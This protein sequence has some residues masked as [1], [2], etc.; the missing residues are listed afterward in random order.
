MRHSPAATTFLVHH[1][2]T[3]AAAFGDPWPLLGQTRSEALLLR[4]TLVRNATDNANE[5]DFSIILMPRVP[6]AY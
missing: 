2:E 1:P 4:V 5:N 3:S 6:T